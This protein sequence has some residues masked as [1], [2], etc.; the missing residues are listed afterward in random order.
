MMRPRVSGMAEKRSDAASRGVSGDG[1]IPH[2]A[3][4]LRPFR[5]RLLRH[6]IERFRGEVLRSEGRVRRVVRRLRRPNADPDGVR[7]LAAGARFRGIPVEWTKISRHR[8]E[9]LAV[10]GNVE[11]W[12]GGTQ[13]RHSKF[14]YREIGYMGSAF[15]RST[16]RDDRTR[17]CVNQGAS[18]DVGKSRRRK[19][20]SVTHATEASGLVT[21]RNTT[22][23]RRVVANTVPC[24]I[25]TRKL[26]AVVCE[27]MGEATVGWANPTS[28][29]RQDFTQNQLRIILAAGRLSR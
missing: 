24:E 15:H 26:R 5:A 16:S 8:S 17:N 14:S 23:F 20:G 4:R 6:W 18:G 19:L 7:S 9:G 29:D 10:A 28:S 25:A 3:R 11:R 1:R 27:A 12:N 2:L 13:F 21:Q 22:W